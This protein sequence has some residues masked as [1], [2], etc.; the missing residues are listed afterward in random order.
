VTRSLHDGA[1]LAVP[2]FVHTG[3]GSD[4]R[5]YSH[6]SIGQSALALPFFALGRWAERALPEPARR[7]LAG[8]EVSVRKRPAGGR[9]EIFAVGLYGPV[10][11]AFLV[12]FF[13]LFERALGVSLRSAALC[14]LLLGST[15][16]VATQATF[17]LRHVTESAALMGALLSFFAWKAGGPARSLWIGSAL[18]SLILLVR[19]P[20][21][22]AGPALAGYVSW[23]LWVRGGHRLD[24]RLLR[25]ALPAI[26]V[27]LLA[28]LAL[29][30]WGDY[31]KWGVPWNVHQFRT[32]SSLH[33]P[34]YVGLYGFLLSPG[35]SI[36]VYSPLLLLAPWSLRR[37]WRER[38]A[39]A[40]VV[41]ALTLTFLVSFSR[42][43]GWTG[44][45][46]APG[47][48]YQLVSVGLLLLPLGL[49]LDRSRSRGPWLAVAA[50]GAAGLFVQVVLM[51]VSWG[52]LIDAMGYR[53]SRPKFSFLFLPDQSPV[54]GA[55]RLVLRGEEIDLWIRS[56]WVGWPGQPPAPGLALGLAVLW[57]GLLAGTLYWI[58]RGI[59]ARAPS[60][61][62]RLTRRRSASGVDRGA[63]PPAPGD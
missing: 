50:L 47:P 17:F 13:F 29:S 35:H 34:L 10:A 14:A 59:R 32:A 25:A 31:L 23:C 45:W 44:L 55:A 15:T 26:G 2:P 4:G 40:L 21:A 37:L 22:V 19:F 11:A 36:F 43:T 53:E 3:R 30:A 39:E 5:S 63:R 49:W 6:F 56:L 46:S 38:R 1:T 51:S 61:S 62:R 7:A 20:A 60:C 28:A 18:A 12:A 42:F 8:P 24:L 52:G 16:Y 9:V 41:L 48:R 57:A 27:P 58:A 33:T 54:L